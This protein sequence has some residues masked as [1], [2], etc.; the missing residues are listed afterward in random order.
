MRIP[1]ALTA[2]ARRALHASKGHA[3]PHGY[4]PLG[5]KAVRVG[6]RGEAV[7]MRPSPR[8]HAHDA[9]LDDA[10]GAD[11]A[12]EGTDSGGASGGAGDAGGT[13]VLAGGATVAGAAAVEVGTVVAGGADAAPA[14]A[15][16]LV[17]AGNLTSHWHSA[18]PTAPSGTTTWIRSPVLSASVSSA[19]GVYVV[20]T[21]NLIFWMRVARSMLCRAGESSCA[22]TQKRRHCRK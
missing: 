3:T 18:P 14:D 8:P 22:Q 9:S 6:D 16:A 13:A 17:S 2:A 11:A 1:P 4:T 15:R 7:R 19:P 5:Y 20:G 10:D 12:G 21:V